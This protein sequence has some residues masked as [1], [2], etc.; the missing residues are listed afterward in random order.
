MKLKHCSLCAKLT[1]LPYQITDID[2][3]GKVESLDL[4]SKCG[5]DYIS[6]DKPVPLDLTHIKTPEELLDVIAG[7]H[8]TPASC[9]CGWTKADFEKY[10]R[11][12]CSECYSFFKE[13]MEEVVFPYHGA[14]QHVGKRPKRQ[15]AEQLNDPVEKIKV[16]KLRLAKAIEL[17]QYEKAGDI[18]K[19]LDQLL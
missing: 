5:A 17:E 3:N 6:D 10:G 16:L 14:S 15:I 18:K 2:R 8:V 9:Q 19:E 4:C 11:M 12:G 7:M 1:A 13:K